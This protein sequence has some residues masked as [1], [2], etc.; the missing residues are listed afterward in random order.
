MSYNMH[1]YPYEYYSSDVPTLYVR[2]MEKHESELVTSTCTMSY[3]ILVVARHG[4]V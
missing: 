2:A 3:N 4:F 1:E